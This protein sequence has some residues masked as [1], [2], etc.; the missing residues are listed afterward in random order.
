MNLPCSE[1]RHP[2]HRDGIH[3]EHGAHGRPSPP[4]RRRKGEQP[5]EDE[6]P[7]RW[8]LAGQGEPCAQ[9][10]EDLLRRFTL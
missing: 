1:A 7:Q 5:A 4:L 6:L 3:A 10:S 9:Y 2:D 8:L